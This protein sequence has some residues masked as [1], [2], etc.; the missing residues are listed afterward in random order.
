MSYESEFDD[1]TWSYQGY[2]LDK[3]NFTTAMVHLYRAEVTRANLWRNRLDTTTNWAVVTTGAALT[4]GFSSAQNPHFVLLLVLILTLI[5]LLM[6]ARR[7]SYY[8]LWY[9]RVR[10]LETELFATMVAPP[11]R[12]SADWGSALQETLLKPAFLIPRWK[13]IGI[14][15]RRNYVWLTTLLLTSWV[16]K[17]SIHPESASG[18]QEIIQRAAIGT[19]VSGPWVMG[20]VACIYFGLLVVMVIATISQNRRP[21]DRPKDQRLPFLLSPTPQEQL[22]VIITNQKEMISKQLM[23]ILRRGV[24]ALDATGMYTGENRD[25]LLCAITRPQVK[26]LYDIIH[27]IDA[28]AFVIV[29]EASGIRGR[30]FRSYE[31]PS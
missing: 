30:G 1:P 7:Y 4:F 18:I 9:H 2:K 17:L 19:L 8:A 27:K 16:L 15:Y 10:L 21:T 12:P 31:P 3:G 25:V 20:I 28:Q 24:T 26:H 29:L 6:E 5:F 22:A 23:K 14:R 11:H 13:A